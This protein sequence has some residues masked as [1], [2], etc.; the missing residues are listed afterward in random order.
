MS[1]ETIMIN[2]SVTVFPKVPMT[3][4][5]S[6]VSSDLS[7]QKMA[8]WF[9]HSCHSKTFSDMNQHQT[10]VFLSPEEFLRAWLPAQGC[11]QPNHCP[12]SWVGGGPSVISWP[13]GKGPGL[14]PRHHMKKYRLNF[15][16]SH[17]SLA[18]R[19]QGSPTY[20]GTWFPMSINNLGAVN[21]SLPWNFLR[22]DGV[23]RNTSR[24]RG[25][26]I[27]YHGLEQP[28]ILT[29]QKVYIRSSEVSYS[30]TYES[31]GVRYQASRST[32]LR[33]FT[34]CFNPTNQA[35]FTALS[36]WRVWSC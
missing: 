28:R 11:S 13:V 32:A 16:A 9:V 23:A 30:N 12:I 4:Q 35:T 31:S 36:F 20:R 17:L 1:G 8:I 10:S 15:V 34:T 2:M 7:S 18:A 27:F 29:G 24:Y 33:P 6:A 26:Q 3:L 21:W 19:C 25:G 22:C 5:L 14:W